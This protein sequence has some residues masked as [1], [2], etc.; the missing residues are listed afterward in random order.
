MRSKRIAFSAL[1]AGLLMV[2]SPLFA[3]H[4]TSISYDESKEVTLT[5]TVTQFVWSNPH[6]HIL[7]D[8]KDGSGNV[9]HWA[10]EGSSP[11][12]WQRQGWTK[13]TVKAGDQITITVHPSKAGTNVG[14][15]TKVVL[16]N[17]KVMARGNTT[18]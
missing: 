18:D 1:V 8:V 16:P 10:A 2:C 15:V 5:G 7:F 4:G 17:G 12:N 11:T 13:S 9:V 3:H 6:A 14:V